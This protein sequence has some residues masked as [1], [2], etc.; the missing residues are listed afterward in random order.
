M[1][2]ILAEILLGIDSKCGRV[3]VSFKPLS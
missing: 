2:V 3:F 1:W